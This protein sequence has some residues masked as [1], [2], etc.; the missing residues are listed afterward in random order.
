M[1]RATR[2]LQGHLPHRR[3]GLAARP[4]RPRLGDLRVRRR[5]GRGARCRTLAGGM[6]PKLQACIDAIHGGVGVRAHHRRPRSR[7][8]CCSSCSPTPASARRS[9]RRRDARSRPPTR[10]TRS[11]SSRARAACCATPTASSTSTSWPGSRSATLGHCHPHVVARRAGAGRA[12]DA[13]LEPVLQRADGRGWPS[14]WP[15]ARSAAER[16]LRQLRRRG[17]RGGDQARAQGAPAAA[18][19]VVAA[20]RLP[21][22]HVRRAVGDAAGV[23]AGAVRAAGARASAPSRRPPRRS[24]AAV[25]ERH[26]RGAARAGPGRVGRAPARRRACCAPRAR[27][28]TAPARRS[29]STRSRRGM[30]RTGSLWAYEQAGVVPD[31]MTL[32]KGLGGGL[33]IGAL[34]IGAAARGRLRA[35]RPRLD[36]RRRPGRLGR[37]AT[38]RST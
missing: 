36:V 30:G 23:Q 35:R 37:G 22:A 31:A 18:D 3:R 6:R 28:A 11:S 21:R 20:R 5:R 2:R 19:I 7:T 16:V 9:G 12:A 15:R 33:P 17:Q 4:G 24:P 10:A 25:D 29:C 8:R 26:R 13:R 38:P 34:V 32:A 14:G 1:A 27:R